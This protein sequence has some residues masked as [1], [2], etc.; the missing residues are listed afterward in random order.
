MSSNRVQVPLIGDNIPKMYMHKIS[1]FLFTFQK[2]FFYKQK[3]PKPGFQHSKSSFMAN[4]TSS[5]NTCNNIPET[6]FP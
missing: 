2:V 3:S 1:Q 6:T 5:Y 4:K